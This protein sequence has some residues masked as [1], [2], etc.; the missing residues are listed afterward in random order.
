[1]QRIFCNHQL[2][3]L[4][5]KTSPAVLNSSRLTLKSITIWAQ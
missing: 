4:A 3:L 1:M 5:R 2:T